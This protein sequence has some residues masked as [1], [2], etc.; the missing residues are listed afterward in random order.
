MFFRAG[1]IRFAQEPMLNATA[2]NLLSRPGGE[3]AFR[4]LYGDYF[5][6]GF[7]LGGDS[8]AFMSVDDVT[9][10]TTDTVTLKATVKVVFFKPKTYTTST[11]KTHIDHSLK[12][13]LSGY[14]TMEGFNIRDPKISLA[15]AQQ[16]IVKMVDLADDLEARVMEKLRVLGITS[17]REL[18]LS[19]CTHLCGSGIVVGILLIPFRLL[20]GYQVGLNLSATN[21]LVS[22]LAFESLV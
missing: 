14:D 8:G 17:N 12:V 19:E 1:V 21:G 5:I 2:Y 10:Q 18:T 20:R 22:S 7:T 15:S 3:D 9:K 13:T 16:K 4:A 11:T 6:S